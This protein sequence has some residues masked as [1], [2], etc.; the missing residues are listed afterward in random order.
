[1]WSARALRDAERRREAGLAAELG[2]TTGRMR[3]VLADLDRLHRAVAQS[4]SAAAA[5]MVD[6]DW[7]AIEALVGMLG[8]APPSP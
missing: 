2:W 7:S 3:D 6:I 4:N 8:D 1:M 5:A